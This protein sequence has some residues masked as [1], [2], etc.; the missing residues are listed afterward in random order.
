MKDIPHADDPLFL[1][2]T[3][4]TMIWGIS[5]EALIV[6]LMASA[7]IFLAVGNPFYMLVY[8]PMHG[9]CYLVCLRDPRTF[10]LIVL[11]LNTKGKCNSKSRWGNVSTAT[12]F[13][14]T[15]SIKG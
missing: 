11:W 13:F 15:R 3:R 1:G 5:Y 7:V 8:I 2:L 6:C 9:V 10:R 12:P 14:N 4:P